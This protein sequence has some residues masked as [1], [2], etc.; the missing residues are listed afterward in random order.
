M[1]I[2]D[3]DNTLLG[4]DSDY[5]WGQF[6][7]ENGYVDAKT[8][9][10]ENQSYYED[11]LNGNIDI[12]SFL[13]FQLRCL[14]ENNIDT[15]LEWRQHFLEEKIRPIILSKGVQLIDKHRQQGHKLLIITATNSFIATPIAGL[16]NI[17][18]LIA[19]EPEIINGTYTG[20]ITG[21]PA[22]A[23]GKVIRYRGWLKQYSITPGE[24]WFYSDSHN[25]LPLLSKVSK[26]IAVD[27][28]NLLRAEAR[29]QGWEIISLR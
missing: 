5:L 12:H 24:S 16:L 3:L 6:L 14:S 28:D 15:L 29:Q 9:R 8:H 21:T 17:D 1:A 23:E 4:G 22:F 10:Q 11:Y 7:S 13:R 27:P 25:D 18:N 2:F 19:T 26:A 20:G